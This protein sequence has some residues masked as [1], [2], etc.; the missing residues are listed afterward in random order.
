M[1][2]DEILFTSM[3]CLGS[4]KH[5]ENYEILYTSMRRL[6]FGSYRY[7]DKIKN[8]RSFKWYTNREWDPNI[9]YNELEKS[10]VKGLIKVTFHKYMVPYHGMVSVV[11]VHI[12]DN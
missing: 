5:N 8:G 11:R 6:G 9:I 2:E 10:G 12:R 7:N 3:R 4:F 1:T